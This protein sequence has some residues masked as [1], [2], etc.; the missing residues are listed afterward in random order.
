M[1]IRHVLDNPTRS[2]LLGP[3]AHLAERRGE[4]LRYPADVCPFVALPD[5]PDERTWQ[6]AAAL[7]GPG[8]LVPFTGV[9]ADVPP[10]WEEVGFGPGVQMID[11]GIDAVGDD[12]AVRLGPADVAEMLDLVARTRPGP[13]LPRTIAL[14]TYLG[15]RRG[16]VLVAMA[17]ERL[18]PPGWT[19]IS[20]VCT[21]P[22]HQGTG[23]ASRLVRAVAA[24]IRARGEI[25]F[26][27]AAATNTNA[28]RL[29]ETLGFRQ[30]RTVTF[31][32]VRIPAAVAVPAQADGPLAARPA[33][34]TGEPAV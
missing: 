18:H 3:H 6:D 21:D 15:I 14:G 13:F 9:D 27:H 10:G 24:G 19:E 22:D 5:E 11:A 16:G 7:L 2:A 31:R 4:V 32:A 25:P 28:I 23:L 30:R 33:T 1:T 20:A 34:G 29:Y 12:D 17:G 26:L 8:A